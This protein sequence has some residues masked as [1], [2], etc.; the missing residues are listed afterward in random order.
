MELSGV[1]ERVER[2]TRVRADSSGSSDVAKTALVDIRDIRAFLD[3][4]E[5][6]LTRR[7]AH[8]TSFPE[9]AIADAAR[10]SLGGASKTLDRANTLNA[11]PTLADALDAATITAGHVDVVTRAAKSL[12]N[13]QRTELFDRIESMV[14]VAE[15]ATVAEFGRRVR[16]E[17]SRITAQDGMNR[18]ERQRRATTLSTWVDPE[19]M[20]CLKGR[21]DPVTGITLA[22][23]L[24]HTVES[25]FSQA[26]PDGCPSDPIEKQ[27]HLRALALA[28]LVQ[29]AAETGTRGGRPEFV[30]VI[31]ITTPVQESNPAPDTPEQTNGVATNGHIDI[32]WPI[33]IEIPH[34]VLADLMNDATVTTIVV[35]NGI[36]LHA[37]GELNLG[38]TTRLANRAQRRALRGLYRTCAI[39]GCTTN[40]SR[41][42]LHHII[43]WRHGGRTDID[44]L[45][46]VCSHHHHKIHDHGWNIAL[47]PNRQ[48][49]IS[50]PDGT[51]RN[52][53]PPHRNAA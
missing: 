32:E 19:G 27:K 24:E 28:R 45:I 35:R 51:V 25:L 46:P 15:T 13:Q 1:I 11:T 33:P 9:A 50:F 38:R 7:I 48:L 8:T 20:W 37:P 52:T 36:V 39:P 47:G 4:T 30:A 10:G 16:A 3:A 22:S 53:G 12:E 17:A 2:I 18:L 29:G 41:C 34:R 14:G 49:T 21:F 23:R 42:K 43:W 6:V 40:Y 26:V 44:N 5:A 31:D